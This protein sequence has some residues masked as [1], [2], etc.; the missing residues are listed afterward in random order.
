[1]GA[2]IDAAEAGGGLALAGRAAHELLDEAGGFGVVGAGGGGDAEQK[3]QRDKGGEC[4]AIVH[5]RIL[6]R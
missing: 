4:V 1:M 6:P 5:C 3:R 2:V